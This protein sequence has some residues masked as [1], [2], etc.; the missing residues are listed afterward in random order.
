MAPLYRDAAAEDRKALTIPA[1]A[2]VVAQLAQRY[3]SK[4]LGALTV[5]RQ[6]DATFFAFGGW[7]SEVASSQDDSG[8]ATLVTVAPGT[9]GFPFTVVA[10]PNGR[11][12]SIRDADRE[13]AFVEQ[14]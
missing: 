12:L 4:E 8:Q 9:S 14:N 3:V 13:Y 5:R 7:S 2:E 1:S 11:S 10:G 6:G